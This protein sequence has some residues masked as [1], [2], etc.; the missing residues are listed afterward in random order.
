MEQIQALKMLVDTHA[1]IYLEDYLH[2]IDEVLQRAYDNG[3]K[4]IILPNLDSSTVKRLLDLSDTYPHL[5]FPLMGLHPSS[6]AAD[7][8]EELQAVEYWLEKRKFYGIGEIGIDLH[9]DKTLKKE[10]QDAFRY[11]IKLAKKHDLPIVIHERSSF[12][13]IISI[14]REEQDGSLKGIFHCF[15]GSEKEASQIVDLGFMMGI[16]GVVTFKNSELQ[17]VIKNIPLENIVVETDSPY[18]APVPKRGKRNEPS[19]IVYVI[20]TI[21][22]VFDLPVNE[23]ACRTTQNARNLFGI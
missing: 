18:L 11:Q 12:Q 2:D 8:R 5:C 23:V 1:H 21:A 20:Q 16:G 13:E 14:V 9:W 3:V 10:Q 19:Y 6:V 4:K 17:K 15:T 7:Y 22:K